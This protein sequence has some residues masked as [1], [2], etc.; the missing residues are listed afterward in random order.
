MS[1]SDTTKTLLV[2]GGATATG[3]TSLAIS[4][5]E[6]LN[7]Q[8]ISFDSRQ[9]FKELNIG[10]AKPSNKELEEV[11]HHFINLV[12]IEDDY[13]I[14]KFE[15]Q[16]LELLDKLFQEHDVVVAVG[17][18]GLYIEALCEGLDDF[19]DIPMEIRNKVNQMLVNDLPKV[20][21]LI[22]D[23]DPE[24]AAKMDLMNPRRLSRVAE[25]ILASGKPYSYFLNRERKPRNFNVL[26]FQLSMERDKLY[27]RINERVDSMMK[28]GLLEEVR[29]LL[30]YR[31]HNALKTV[32]YTEL[33]DHLDGEFS[34]EEAVEKIKQH[35]RNYAK[36]QITW[37]SNR[38]NFEWL[39]AGDD[40]ESK[41]LERLD[42]LQLPSDK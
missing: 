20:Q 11:Q 5:A 6:K 2:I 24:Q 1:K 37:F 35:T 7:T 34:L 9:I 13:N 16:A 8:I 4:I 42:N 21:A 39:E 10:T 14:S 26:P 17:G 15:T 3:K 27:N 41:V 31:D 12:S 19:P 36:R 33:F 23:E 30:P 29:S 22:L 38:M 18:S 25:V 28:E 40:A 32:G